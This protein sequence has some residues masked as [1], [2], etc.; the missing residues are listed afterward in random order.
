MLNCRKKA[1]TL[2]TAGLFL[3][4]AGATSVFAD[5]SRTSIKHTQRVDL[6]N[7]GYPLVNEIPANSSAITSLLTAH[8]DK[9]Y[10]ATSGEQAYL[11]VFD[12]VINKVRHLGKIKDQAGVHHALAED[13][14]GLIY[15]G[16]G[17]SI[18]DEIEIPKWAPKPP[19]EDLIKWDE[20]DKHFRNYPDHV[21]YVLK[22][23]KGA[24]GWHYIDI[25]LWNEIK[26]VFKNYPSGHLYRYNPTE[27]SPRVKLADMDCEL[28]DLG[29]PVP[30]NSIYALTN[31][32]GGDAVYGLTYPEGHFFIYNIA[33]KKFTDLGP[34]DEQ[35]VFHGPERHWRSLPRALICDDAGRVYTTSTDGIIVYYCP[36]S[37]KI[38]STQ[39]K[40]PGDYYYSQLYSDYPVVEYFTKGLDG[41]IYGGSCD[42]HLFRFDPGKLELVNLGKPHSARRLRCLAAGKDGKIY[43][44]L[45][46]RIAGRP[47]Q[48]FCY[49][50]AKG[51]FQ[52]IGLLIVDRSPYYSWRGLQFDSMTTG[53]DGTIFFGESERRSHL[54]MYMP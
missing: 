32:P 7:L 25:I 34:I 28:E 11:F 35:V 29:T 36:T 53:A 49:D 47:C 18:L 42:G 15:I 23:N 31:S 51:G 26:N 24:M 10:G 50:P 27:S 14:D 16:T 22:Q 46:E 37:G 5:W 45:G 1:F 40:I 19:K 33:A 6:R 21:R 43:F 48:F 44:V 54:F 30:N 3:F 41:L 38:H 52:D 9:I 17:R 12:P 39:M 2:I 4:T 13:K 20:V 8:N